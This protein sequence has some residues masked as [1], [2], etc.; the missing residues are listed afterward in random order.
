[1][2]GWF[3]GLFRR[4]HPPIGRDGQEKKSINS[5][6]EQRE[7]V[8]VETDILTGGKWNWFKIILTIGKQAS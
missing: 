1:M 4:G 3:H 2:I 8:F 6:A 7:L 5:E